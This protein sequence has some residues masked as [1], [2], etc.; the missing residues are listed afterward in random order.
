MTTQLVYSDQFLT[1]TTP[2]HPENAQ[3]LT[4]IINTLK[5]SSLYQKIQ[6]L[7]PTPLAESILREIHTPEMIELI[8]TLSNKTLSWID[9]DTYVCKNDFEIATLAAGGLTQLCENILNN[10]ATN[11]FALI[12]PPGHHATTSRSMGFCL[13]NNAALAAHT[14]T[15]KEKKILIVDI[16]CHHGNGTQQ[17]FYTRND[18]LYQ[19]FHLSPHYPGTG[20]IQEI[21]LGEGLGYTQNAPLRHGNGDQAIQT[22]LKEIFLPT[23]KQFKPDFIIISS[24]YDSHHSDLLGGLT[25]TTNLYAYITQAYQ[26]IQPKIACTLEGGYNLEWIGNCFIAQLG[27]LMNQPQTIDDKSK[28]HQSITPVIKA[29]KK[30]LGDYWS[31]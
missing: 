25:C 31:L 17:I 5:R 1:H 14:L 4:T 7:P 16:D 12:R 13:F 26:K 19:S 11:G 28:E 8:K 10:Q 24:G 3:R 20:E 21:G 18:V 23:A 2:G 6:M 27:Q 29:L 9:P 15:K 22:L 30:E